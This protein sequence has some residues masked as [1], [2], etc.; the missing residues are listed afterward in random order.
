MTLPPSP[1]PLRN[2]VSGHGVT[3]LTLGVGRL[4]EPDRDVVGEE[5]GAVERHAADEG[6]EVER[7]ARRGRRVVDAELLP[8]RRQ[9]RR[10]RDGSDGRRTAELGEL[11]L[12]RRAGG[13]ALYPD[14]GGVL[15]PAPPRLWGI[16]GG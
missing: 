16:S 9:R 2:A 7:R 11:G 1:E 12:D 4:R 3:F 6:V 15:S 13:C 14:G 10:R 5:A 8:R